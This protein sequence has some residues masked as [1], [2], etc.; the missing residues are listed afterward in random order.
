MVAVCHC[1]N[2]L[3]LQ[4]QC[5]IGYFIQ[6]GSKHNIAPPPPQPLH[7]CDIFFSK[8]ACDRWLHIIVD[9][10]QKGGTCGWNESVPLKKKKRKHSLMQMRSLTMSIS[11]HASNKFT[12]IFV[13]IF[14]L[15][16]IRFGTYLLHL[17]FSFNQTSQ[18]S[19][20]SRIACL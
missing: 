6:R 4:T 9:A 11:S 8:R 16:D 1:W 12:T 7:Y 17:F 18:L 5:T 19:E 14:A 3:L 2:L 10:S 20:F 15:S 13:G